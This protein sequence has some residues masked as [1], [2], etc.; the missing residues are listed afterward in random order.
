MSVKWHKHLP[1]SI[2]CPLSV[3]TLPRFAPFPLI[4]RKELIVIHMTTRIVP[5]QALGVSR[6]RDLYCA[7]LNH[8]RAARTLYIISIDRVASLRGYCVLPQT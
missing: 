1:E 5:T 4:R 3:R 7:R 2:P 6:R 8:I